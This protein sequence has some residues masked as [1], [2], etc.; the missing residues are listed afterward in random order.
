MIDQVRPTM[1]RQNVFNQYLGQE[2]IISEFV[3]AIL[4]ILGNNPLVDP[5]KM[6]SCPIY[7]VN[8]RR[9]Y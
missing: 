5:E 3:V 4:V 2:T 6:P 9:F 8:I 7:R 1:V